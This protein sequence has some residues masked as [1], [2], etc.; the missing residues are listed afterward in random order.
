[1]DAWI[2]EKENFTLIGSSKSHW[3][4]GM[5]LEGWKVVGRL[6]SLWKSEKLLKI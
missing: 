1:M 3:K 4:S 5:I 2:F 6:E